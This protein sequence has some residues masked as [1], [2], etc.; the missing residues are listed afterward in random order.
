MT[1]HTVVVVSSDSE[2]L[3]RLESILTSVGYVVFSAETLAQTLELL[4]NDRE[5]QLVLGDFGHTCAPD[6]E[7]IRA[8]KR[9]HPGVFLVVVVSES[10]LPAI[11]EAVARDE[12]YQYIFSPWHEE[13]LLLT[14]RRALE[15]CDLNRQNLRLLRRV[16]DKKEK[17]EAKP[18]S[19]A[20]DVS[21]HPDRSPRPAAAVGN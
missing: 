14:V 18:A 20:D 10:D 19:Q 16:A 12:I 21:P 9:A 4:E 5:V 17:A 7:L 11:S 3:E 8:V 6:L 2:S 15:H 1:L 13:S